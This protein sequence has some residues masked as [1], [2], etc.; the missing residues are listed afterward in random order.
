MTPQSAAAASANANVMVSSRPMRSDTQ[1]KKGRVRPLQTRSIESASGTAAA[2]KTSALLWP[3]STAKL[4]KFE[5]TIRPPVD[6]M[7]IMTNISQKI[8]ERSMAPGVAPV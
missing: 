5:T 3:K 8:G 7:V 2:P 6:I 1:P 4:L